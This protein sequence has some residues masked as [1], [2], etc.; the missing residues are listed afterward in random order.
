MFARRLLTLVA[1]LL[2]V[3]H[4]LAQLPAGVYQGPCVQIAQTSYCGDQGGTPAGSIGYR[5]P[6]VRGSLDVPSSPCAKPICDSRQLYGFIVGPT[7]AGPYGKAYDTGA[8]CTLKGDQCYNSQPIADSTIIYT[9]G[10]A[11]AQAAA[12]MATNYGGDSKSKSF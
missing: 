6:Y 9:Y 2:S 4:C 8:T 5:N 3:Q 11:E 12:D 10:E 7:Y 1:C